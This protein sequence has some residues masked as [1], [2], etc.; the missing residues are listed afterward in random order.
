MLEPS[1]S[2]KVSGSPVNSDWDWT[3]VDRLIYNSTTYS[4]WWKV[5]F[6]I[7]VPI[8]DITSSQLR[9]PTIDSIYEDLKNVRT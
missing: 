6:S 1:Q 5:E 9:V 4:T 2:L 3:D 8:R 7:F